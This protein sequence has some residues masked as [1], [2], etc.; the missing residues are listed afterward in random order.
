MTG[1]I[2][3]NPRARSLH[4]FVAPRTPTGPV[5]VAFDIDGVLLRGNQPLPHARESLLRLVAADIPF[6]FLTNGGG[7]RES[8]KASKLEEVLGI[9]VA[10]AQVV[11][12]HTPLRQA[13]VAHAHEKILV[14]GCRDVVDVARS[15][16]AQRVYTVDDLARDEPTRYPFLHWEQRRIEPASEREAPFGAVF[17]LHDPNNWGAEIQVWLR[18][19]DCFYGGKSVCR[20]RNDNPLRRRSAQITL[21]VI[22]GG[23]PLGSGRGQT[24]PVFS[25]NPD[26]IFAGEWGGRIHP[27]TPLRT[28]AVTFTLPSSP[29]RRLP[30]LAPRRGRLYSRAARPLP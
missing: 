10:T 25:S 8:K 12:S 14:L 22:R 28:A 17:I 3:A 20:G 4:S 5:G 18:G 2:L 1:R 7:E 26:L 6:I 9:P 15:Y 24:V 23:W 16:G 27:R 19:R 29:R 13:V 21:D 30:S 11:L